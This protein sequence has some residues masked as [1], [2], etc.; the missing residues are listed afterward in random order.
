MYNV[1]YTKQCA[2]KFITC[3]FGLLYP[4]FL[5]DCYICC[6]HGN[7]LL[8]F[9]FEAASSGRSLTCSSVATFQGFY[10][11]LLD[12]NYNHSDLLSRN[13]CR[14]EE[15]S[16]SLTPFL[17]QQ[18]DLKSVSAFGIPFKCFNTVVLFCNIL[19]WQTVRL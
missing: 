14:V 8:K 15:L 1:C 3:L 2:T 12:F 7:F 13:L 11:V 6:F 17:S 16:H 19:G 4:C 18:R 5:L 10:S 9:W